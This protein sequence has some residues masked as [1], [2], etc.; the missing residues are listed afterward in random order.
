[1]RNGIKGFVIAFVMICMA[2]VVMPEMTAKAAVEGNYEYEERED[3]SVWI[4]HYTGK[5]KKVVIPSQLGGK[6]V[7]GIADQAFVVWVEVMPDFVEDASTVTEVVFPDTLTYIGNWNFYQLTSI[8]IPKNVTYIGSRAF[9][10]EH[11]ESITVDSANTVYRSE[12]NAIITERVDAETGENIVE[13]VRACNSTVIPDGVTHIGSD[14]FFDYSLPG[15]DIPGSVTDI[16]Y[17]AFSGCAGLTS[18][19]IPESVTTIGGCAFSNCDNLTTI[20]LNEGLNTIYDWAFRDCDKL[21]NIIIP[22]SVTMIGYEAFAD[23]DNL[24]KVVLQEGLKEIGH[25]AFADCVK[26]SNITIPQTVIA[27]Q[28]GAFSGQNSIKTINVPKNV[29][30]IGYGAFSGCGGIVVDS[31]NNMYDSRENSNAV[32][33]KNYSELWFENFIGENYPDW[34]IEDDVEYPVKGQLIA[35]CRN[36]TI[37]SDVT[38]LGDRA[39]QGCSGL[40][41]I[42]IPAGVNYI[43]E[44]AFYKCSDLS[45]I[46]VAEENTAYYSSDN[47]LIATDSQKLVAASKDSAIP[48]NIQSIGEGVFYNRSDL[49]KVIIP[50]S[51]TNI[52]NS[53]FEGCSNLTS[54]TLPSSVSYIDDIA[55]G[56]CEN[57]TVYVEPGSYAEE[58]AQDYDYAT[59]VYLA[60][61]KCNVKILSGDANPTV[62]YAGTTDVS[63]KSIEVPDAVIIEDVVYKVVSI[64]D[65][66][67][68]GNENVTKVVSG[69]NVASIGEKAFSDC[70][71][72]EEVVLSASLESVSPDVFEGTVEAED[73][74]KLKVT[75]P[76]ETEDVSKAGIE[77]ITN[78]Q[79]VVIYVPE[80]SKT[81][82]YLKQFDYL[83]IITY[84]P[85]Q[86]PAENKDNEQKVETPKTT[87]Q[88]TEAPKPQVEQPEKGKKYTVNN[89]TYKVT[90]SK[91]VIFMGTSK[92]SLK[93]LTIPAKVTILGQSLEVT[94]IEKRAM[95][96]CS[97]LTTVVIGSN[98]KTIGDEAFMNCSHLKKITIGKNVKTIGKKAFYGDK[99]VTRITFKGAKLS[100]IGKKALSKVPKK[101]KIKAPKKAKKKYTKMLNC[102]K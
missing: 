5:E 50:E 59:G 46:R 79:Y 63:A 100:K 42:F 29:G 61:E 101:V 3:G 95:K 62:A 73:E 64:A 51:V 34:E 94:A 67:F 55:F 35:G 6:N 84:P 44:F 89:L 68:S 56:G 22:K 30:I 19:T 12:N 49:K 40:T 99:K 41:D 21:Q 97:K 74:T 72:L 10:T 82:I 69:K 38:E 25:Y 39:F 8:H 16:G 28:E 86:T 4:T 43:G 87:E 102:T 7:T 26:L 91:T 88:V 53:A 27:I 24:E 92:K 81:E 33:V 47:C 13:L 14:S 57:M 15:I 17:C 52:G 20:N 36:S 23:C 65:N 45:S 32:I 66:A 71:S 80:G 70:P 54:I 76:E 18:I 98:V 77:N 75:I 83:V 11:V 96:K 31:N 2:G 9:G 1:M 60:G 93:T 90:S 78:I 48:D 37:P 58:W 85:I